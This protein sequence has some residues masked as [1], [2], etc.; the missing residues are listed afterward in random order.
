MLDLTDENTY[1]DC[2]KDHHYWYFIPP[3][4]PIRRFVYKRT[5]KWFGFFM[6][7][8]IEQTSGPEYDHLDKLLDNIK[9]NYKDSVEV[10]FYE[11]EG[12][13]YIDVMALFKQQ[14]FLLP[15]KYDDLVYMEKMMGI[16]LPPCISGEPNL[17]VFNKFGETFKS[18][19]HFCRFVKA[20]DD[21]QGNTVVLAEA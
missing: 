12:Q 4:V 3:T 13:F 8:S 21:K 6:S 20:I 18:V 16:P 5:R 11:V 14:E 9:T 15:L 17:W 7:E 10:P 1:Y 19:E 2:L